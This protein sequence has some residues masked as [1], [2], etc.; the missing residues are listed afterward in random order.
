MAQLAKHICVLPQNHNELWILREISQIICLWSSKGIL[1]GRPGIVPHELFELRRKINTLEQIGE[2]ASPIFVAHQKRAIV[3]S[4]LV[5]FRRLDVVFLGFGNLVIVV[6][7]DLGQE[8][9]ELCI[10]VG[11]FRPLEFPFSVAPGVSDF[12]YAVAFVQVFGCGVRQFKYISY[13][14]CM[15]SH[16]ARFLAIV[17]YFLLSIAIG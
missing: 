7:I 15:A 2:V 4:R 14:I 6:F 12:E 9:S 16:N 13:S 1:A 5:A 8:F 10:V 11:V 17:F 3:S